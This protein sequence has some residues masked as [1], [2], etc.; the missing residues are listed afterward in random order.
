MSFS[1]FL[2]CFSK[3]PLFLVDCLDLYAVHLGSVFDFCLEVELTFAR[4]MTMSHIRDS[5][6]GLGLLTSVLQNIVG[7]DIF[8]L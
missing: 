2:I 4:R 8:A 3:L 5:Y 7:T 6:V 1:V